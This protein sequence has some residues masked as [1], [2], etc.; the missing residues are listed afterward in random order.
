[1]FIMKLLRLM[2]Q[3][4]FAVDNESL[5]EYPVSDLKAR[6]HQVAYLSCRT[7]NEGFSVLQSPNEKS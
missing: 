3:S 7:F 5:L 6:I 4:R 1:M 2:N